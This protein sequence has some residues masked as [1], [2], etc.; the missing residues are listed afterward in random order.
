MV[1][2]VCKFNRGGIKEEENKGEVRNPGMGMYGVVSRENIEVKGWVVGSISEY[3]I[4][5]EIRLGI[6]EEVKGE[7][8]GVN[9]EVDMEVGYNRGKSIKMSPYVG[10]NT[11]AIAVKGYKEEGENALRLEVEGKEYIRSSVKTGIG[12]V[13]GGKRFG[14][15][16]RG[17]VNYVLCGDEIEIG[18]RIIGT[19]VEMKSK[20]VELGKVKIEG[21]I[22]GNYKI[23]ERWEGCV[24]VNMGKAINYKDIECNLGIRYSF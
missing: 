6:E 11:K 13:G 12:M 9:G 17:G 19:D 20:G 15:N 7:T 10:V 5:R 21:E 16:V 22:G 2:V 24:E 3:E 4:R 23:G 8:K 14:W 1:G 18:S